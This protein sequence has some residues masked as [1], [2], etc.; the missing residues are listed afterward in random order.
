[1][2]LRSTDILRSWLWLALAASLLT[3]GLSIRQAT[4]SIIGRAIDCHTKD[5]KLSGINQKDLQALGRR[6]KN[7]NEDAL[8]KGDPQKYCKWLKDVI[9]P[10]RERVLRRMEARMTDKCG[11]DPIMT[12]LRD[13]SLYAVKNLKR[14][15][16]GPCSGLRDG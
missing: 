2:C 16:S 11:Y 3:V 10:T 1:M 14:R 9:M 7:V 8:R 5:A 13:Y 4:A 6:I 15:M 12:H